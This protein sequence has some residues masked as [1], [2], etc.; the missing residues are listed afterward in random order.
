MFEE[1]KVRELLVRVLMDVQEMSGREVIEITDDLSPLEDLEG[2]DSLNA[3]EACTLLS[4]LVGQEI[5][6]DVFER[7]R[8]RHATVR[9]IVKRL[10]RV[11]NATE[12]GHHE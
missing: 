8:D 5:E 11:L 12:V 1:S 4:D 3:T 6:L 10:C 9:D 7:H 2:F